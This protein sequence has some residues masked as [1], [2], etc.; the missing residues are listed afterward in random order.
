[1]MMERAV[2]AGVN[3]QGC[4]NLGALHAYLRKHHKS[5]VDINALRDIGLLADRGIAFSDVEVSPV[6]FTNIYVPPLHVAV[7]ND[8]YE[9]VNWMIERGAEINSTIEYQRD[10]GRYD[11]TRWCPIGVAVWYGRLDVV[12]V[13]LKHG[14][15]LSGLYFG[16]RSGQINAVH[17]AAARGHTHL[18]DV[19]VKL[20]FDLTKTVCGRTPPHYALGTPGNETMIAEL[21]DRGAK[22]QIG[23]RDVAPVRADLQALWR[24]PATRRVQCPLFD[25]ISSGCY[26]NARFL[27]K[28]GTGRTLSKE[29]ARGIVAHAFD[30]KANHIAM[31]N[32][33]LRTKT[34]RKV[35]TKRYGDC[36]GE[37]WSREDREGIIEYMFSSNHLDVTD[38]ISDGRNVLFMA[39]GAKAFRSAKLVRFLLKRPDSDAVINLSRNGN[40]PL[41][42]VVKE[43]TKDLGS[44][45]RGG[46]GKFN[47][48]S[49]AAAVDA[50]VRPPRDDLSR[51]WSHRMCLALDRNGKT[52]FDLVHNFCDRQLKRRDH[53]KLTMSISFI[54]EMI[55]LC[56]LPE[57][58]RTFE[59]ERVL[60]LGRRVDAIPNSTGCTIV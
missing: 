46:V 56:P 50:L 10:H 53:A 39:L 54:D 19:L 21:I 12:K 37:R 49:H 36:A 52:A 51:N 34:M 59:K 7:A 45:P 55:S 1:M 43:F 31:E 20:S 9:A 24:S 3:L 26:G 33:A 25:A 35:Q 8:Q 44:L 17:I 5:R 13:L 27:L 11:F 29:T 28:H 23:P 6:T 42:I 30:A 48:G 41:H 57:E 60:E 32:G 18:L 22:S 58:K 47:P 38:E 15:A 2:A 4:V 14:A 16:R 40:S